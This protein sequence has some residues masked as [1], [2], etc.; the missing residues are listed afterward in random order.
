MNPVLICLIFAAA[1][2][3]APRHAPLPVKVASLGAC[4]A[5]DYL[6]VYGGHCGKTHTYSTEDVIGRFFRV[7]LTGGEWE[8]LPSG[9]ASQGLALVAHGGR[10]LRVGGMQPRN[11]PDQPADNIS[12]KDVA[13]YDPAAR[14][15]VSL[16]DMP[17][18]RSSHDAVVVGD[19]L[20]VVGG[21]E[22]R[23]KGQ[24]SVW[25]DTAYMLDLKAKTPAWRTVP[26][27]FKRRAL[28]AAVVGGKVHVVGGMGPDGTTLEVDVYDPASGKW[29]KG[30][31]VPG[32]TR[33]G[34]S[35]AACA[36][37]GRLVVSTQDGR[38]HALSGATWGLVTK[39]EMR[40][41]VHRL[42]P[43]E[44]SRV[45][46]VGGFSRD[47]DPRRVEEIELP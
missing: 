31:T 38:L 36:Q 2:P 37:G 35:P 42:V 1:P 27:P 34:F 16:P 23:G 6:Y 20:Y 30:P 41:M 3:V 11:K 26:Q 29:A 25:H 32:A 5:G 39:Q 22:M 45:V 21:W 33:L 44:G 9:P 10:V 7:K 46:V 15:W 19:T 13:A 12:L 17:A 24:A 8:E 40:R 4:V 14:R 43:G 28:S 47:D 18:G